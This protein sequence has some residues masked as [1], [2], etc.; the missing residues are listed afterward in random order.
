M[1][2]WTKQ[3]RQAIH[4]QARKSKYLVN[5]FFQG[6]PGTVGHRKRLLPGSLSLPRF[7][8]RC[9]GEWQVS[10]PRQFH[11]P[12]PKP[13]TPIACMPRWHILGRLTPNSHGS[14][15]MT[16]TQ[17]IS[18]FITVH[19][20]VYQTILPLFVNFCFSKFTSGPSFI[21]FELQN[22]RLCEGYI[23]MLL[24]IFLVIKH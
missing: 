11:T 13:H 10:L 7:I 19:Y 1:S 12:A 20:N 14:S 18:S 8:H 15:E 22:S 24:N 6:H 5:K 3:G 23:T 21:H 16:Q 4:R 2:F 17:N 9:Q